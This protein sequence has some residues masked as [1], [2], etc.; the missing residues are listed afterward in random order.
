[1]HVRAYQAAELWS[2]I[3]RSASPRIE[4][5]LVNSSFKFSDFLKH[6]TSLRALDCEAEQRVSHS[7]CSLMSD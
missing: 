6:V 7:I 3:K 5:L 4:H 1:M 2:G